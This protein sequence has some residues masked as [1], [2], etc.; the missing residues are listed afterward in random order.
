VAG[1]RFAVHLVPRAAATG[2]EGTRD[3]A[4]RIRVTAPPVDGAANEALRRLLAG[5]LGVARSAVEIVAGATGRRKVVAVD[6][7]GADE[8]RGRWPGLAV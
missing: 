5:E 6:G 4:L 8:V 2:I 3:G 1:V 7:I